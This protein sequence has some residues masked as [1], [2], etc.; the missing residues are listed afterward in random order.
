MAEAELTTE[1]QE[2]PVLA[3]VRDLMFVSKIVATA[4]SAGEPLKVV[5]DPAKLAGEAGRR[6]L[7]VPEG[8]TVRTVISIGYPATAARR[9]IRKPLDSI[10]HSE[11]YS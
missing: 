2:K 5:R 6:L 3:L 10:V 4:R 1:K 7:N 11:K 8:R 9:G